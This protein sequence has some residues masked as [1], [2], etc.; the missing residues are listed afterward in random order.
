MVKVTK[1]EQRLIGG[2]W[3]TRAGGVEVTFWR[4]FRMELRRNSTAMVGSGGCD[5][6]LARAD[7]DERLIRLRSCR[8]R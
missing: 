1:N 3:E 6:P 2:N 5:Y 8:K 7:S 4:D